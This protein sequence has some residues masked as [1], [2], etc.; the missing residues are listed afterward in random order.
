MEEIVIC[1]DGY[2]RIKNAL[3]IITH[4]YPKRPITIIIPG[5]PD[6]F[7]FFNLI[8]EKLFHN[9][10]NLIYFEPFYP[11]P[12]RVK[13][14]GLNKIFHVLSDIIRERRYL[15]ETFDEYLAGI[16]GRELFFLDRG[17]T[18]FSL[19]KKL[20]KRNRLVYI[21]SYQTQV[22]PRQYTPTN[23]VDLAKLIILKLTYGRGIALGKSFHR[24][25]RFPHMSD[26]FME[27]EF[28]RVID[29]EERDEML[30]DFRLSQFKIF[31]TGKYS[32]IYFF[33][34]VGGYTADE[35][36]F[37]RE[38]TEIFNILSKYF[39]ESEIARKYHPGYRSDG[40]SIKTGD[41]LPDYIPA[42]LLYDDNVKIYLG[43]C[44]SAMANVEKGLV[45]SLLDLISFGN[46]QTREQLK[47]ILLRTA[48]SKI[49]YPKSLDEFEE[50]LIN[51]KQQTNA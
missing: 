45:V 16:E 34:D 11:D 9:D 21:S 27:R 1:A 50:I 38:F 5:N 37:R 41:V 39:P 48:R 49:L 6:L 17:F 19:V 51:M 42:E 35:N 23:I 20:G 40:T 36:T 13:A 4:N 24:K 44:S 18:Q 15:K 29:G 8:N 28:D 3:Y 12:R 10:I 7:K 33:D 14:S 43:A 46:E 31:D 22:A 2:P 25:D 47:E 26:K 32:I 30:K